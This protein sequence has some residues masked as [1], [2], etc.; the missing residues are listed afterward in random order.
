MSNS[1]IPL[2]INTLSFDSFKRDPKRDMVCLT[3][4]L[5]IIRREEEIVLVRKVRKV[6]EIDVS[7]TC[8]ATS[9]AISNSPIAPTEQAV[10]Q[11]QPQHP[12]SE[13]VQTSA[14]VYQS[15]SEIDVE[16]YDEEYLVVHSRRNC[17]P[18]TPETMATLQHETAVSRTLQPGTYAI[19]LKSGAFDYQVESE[20]PGEPWV[21]LWL[22]GG[23]VI[24]RQTGVAVS[25]TWT[26]L[27]GLDDTATIEVLEPTNLCAFFL[28]TYLADNEGEVTITVERAGYVEDLVVHSQRNCYYISPETMQQ[29]Q[30]TAVSRTLQPGTYDIKLKSGAF[31][32]RTDSGHQGEPLVLLWLYGGLVMNHK[33]GI[34]V[35]VTWSSLNGYSDTLSLSVLEPATLCAFFYDTY[36][37]DNEGEV[38]LSVARI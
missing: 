8:P 34:P 14:Q 3:P 10:S 2:D 17:L 36:L 11:S 23:R 20:H 25:A 6:E 28:D 13:N 7:P 32:Y 27:N 19:R 16:E 30:Q 12:S 18:M 15:E 21:L 24:N 33:T 26:S 31:S 38:T 29:L 37:E 4:I 35:G 22:Y 5:T 1:I 9:E